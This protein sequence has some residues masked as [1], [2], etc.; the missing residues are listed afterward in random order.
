MSDCLSAL[1]LRFELRARGSHSGAIRGP[2]DFHGSAGASHL[3]LVRRGPLGVTDSDGDPDRQQRTEAGREP[4]PKPSR[5][6]AAIHG[7][8]LVHEVAAEQWPPRRRVVSS[9]LLRLRHFGRGGL[10]CLSGWLKRPARSSLTAAT[11]ER[12]TLRTSSCTASSL[13]NA[14]W[15]LK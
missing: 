13:S 9:D 11:T 5:T 7:S 14:S 8:D 1:L 15:L 3:H 12:A 2:A 6:P 10:V 4:Y